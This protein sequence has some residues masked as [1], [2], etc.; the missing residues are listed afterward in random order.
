[1]YNYTNRSWSIPEPYFLL[2]GLL[3]GQC[4]PWLSFPRNFHLCCCS[5][6]PCLACCLRGRLEEHKGEGEGREGGGEGEAQRAVAKGIALREGSAEGTG[7]EG[8]REGQREESTTP[9]QVSLLGEAL[10]LV[11]MVPLG[12]TAQLLQRQQISW[13]KTLPQK[14]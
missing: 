2:G 6:C 4:S 11:I 5:W 7:P 14:T 10:V 12:W 1:M 8:Y 9:P 13:N 3:H